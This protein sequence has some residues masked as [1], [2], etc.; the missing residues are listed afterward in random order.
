MYSGSKSFNVAI[1]VVAIQ[2]LV[3]KHVVKKDVS[4]AAIM[5]H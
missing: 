4:E 1:H 2:L 3:K 5:Q